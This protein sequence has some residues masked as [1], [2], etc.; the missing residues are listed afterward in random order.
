MSHR[1]YKPLDK[2]GLRKFGLVTGAI[3]IG[4]FGIIPM[5]IK[6]KTTHWTL[7]RWPLFP[8]V[9]LIVMGLLIPT[10]LAPVHRIWM[11]ASLVMGWVNTRIILTVVFFVVLTPLGLLRRLLGKDTLG[12]EARSKEA[13]ETAGQGSY[14]TD[15]PALP[16]ERMKEPF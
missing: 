10:A 14:R 5:I 8:G 12:L 16:R 11:K 13:R 9:P 15:S 7:P 2:K 4:L 1:E 3:F 6:H